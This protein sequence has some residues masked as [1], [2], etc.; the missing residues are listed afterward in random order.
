MLGQRH[1]FQSLGS[2]L[3]LIILKSRLGP[4]HLKSNSRHCSNVG[5]SVPTE[6]ILKRLWSFAQILSHLVKSRFS[7]T[8]QIE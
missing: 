4:L 3:N 1:I 6:E 7:R 5:I 2:Q 8:L